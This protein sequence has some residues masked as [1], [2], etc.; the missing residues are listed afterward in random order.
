[1]HVLYSVFRIDRVVEP[2]KSIRNAVVK[3]R[4][5]C[6]R[7][8]LVAV[9]QAHSLSLVMPELFH[10]IIVVQRWEAVQ[11]LCYCSSVELSCIYILSIYF[12]DNFVAF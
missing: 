9:S 11:I 5:K 1:M 3:K 6:D 7:L 4:T 12:S 10:I 8:V 2:K